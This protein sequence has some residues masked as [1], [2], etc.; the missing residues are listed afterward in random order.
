MNEAKKITV[1]G[2]TG[3]VGTQ[4]LDVAL[5]GNYTVDALAFGSNIKVGEEQIRR[6]R[7]RFV[8]IEHE[9]AARTL[10]TSIADTATK[11]YVGKDSVCEMIESLDSDVCV[12]L[13]RLYEVMR[14]F[15]EVF[16]THIWNALR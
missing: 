2:S 5:C 4:A 3:S 8:A 15:G 7:P 11:L 10:R 14:A 9:N 13:S 12:P 16:S 6:F 1:L